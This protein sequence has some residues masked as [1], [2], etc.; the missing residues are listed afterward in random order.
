LRTHDHKRLALLFTVGLL[1]VLVAGAVVGLVMRAELATPASELGIAVH[2]RLLSSHG[3]LMAFVFAIPL[4]SATL[5]NYLLPL[6]LG[7]RA[8]AF[9]RLGLATFYLWAGGA[10]LV[11]GALGLGRLDSGWTFEAPY[12]GELAGPGAEALAALG[13]LLVA[14][15]VLLTAVGFIVTIHKL[16]APG[17]TWRRLPHFVSALY[18]AS[19]ITVVAA[20][21]WAVTML[22]VIVEKAL[23]IGLFDPHLGGDPLLLQHFL[24]AGVHP[25]LVATTVA[26]LGVIAEVLSVHARHAVSRRVFVGGLAALAALGFLQWGEHLVVAGQSEL[27]DVVFSFFALLGTAPLVVLVTGLVMSL[28][29]GVLRLDAPLLF[30]LGA[31]VCVGLGA[32]ARVPLVATSTAFHLQGSTFSTGQLHASLGGLALAVVAGLFHWFP[33]LTGRHVAAVPARWAALVSVA[34]VSLMAVVE[35]VLGAGGTPRHAPGYPAE[36]QAL[37]LLAGLGGLLLAAGLLA[38]IGTLVLGARAGRPATANPWDG[39]SLEW[40]TSSPPPRDNF[41]A[42]PHV[43]HGPYAVDPRA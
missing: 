15:S 6:M 16:R 21:L 19:W 30:A 7:A 20:P 37:Q 41:A 18:V 27:A 32:L 14:A 10:A 40:A 5:G 12:A 42:T 39:A 25:L 11:L 8:L 22:L 38:A 33:K 34:G 23:G 43:D 2:R 29:G 36:H 1:V 13:L 31:L 3:L 35:L 28:R 24:W 9:P 4:V 26:T 17:M